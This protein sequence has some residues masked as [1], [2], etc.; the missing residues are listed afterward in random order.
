MRRDWLRFSEAVEILRPNEKLRRISWE[1][2]QYLSVD[3]NLNIL[4]LTKPDSIYQVKYLL[5]N[6]DSLA[7]DW[8]I[9][10][11]PEKYEDYYNP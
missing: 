6:N 9:F 4:Y 11:L 1:T 2:G 10:S 3:F 5:S 8:Q 7:C